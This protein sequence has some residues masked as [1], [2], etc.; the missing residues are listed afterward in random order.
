MG[1]SGGPVLVTGASSG[2]G[3]STVELLGSMGHSVLAGARRPEDLESLS[4]I[5]NLSP[6]SLDVTRTEDVEMAVATVRSQGRGL[7][8][9]VNTA[10]IGNLGPLAEMTVEEIHDVLAVNFDGMCRM[11]TAMFPLLQESKGRVIN[12]SSIGGFLVE[13]LLGPYNISKHAVEAYSDVL[14]EEVAPFGVRVIT[15]EPGAFQTRIYDKSLIRFA[16]AIRQKWAHSSSVFRD[17]VLQTLAYLEQ[18]EVRYRKNYPLPV[19]VARVI[20][21]ALF[22]D[23]PK[24]RYLVG[25]VKEANAVV[26][27]LLE[28]LRQVNSS[29]PG[30]L[31]RDELAERLDR[32]GPGR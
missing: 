16:E 21:E 10:G 3:R 23:N 15:I 24:P 13:P 17:Q 4:R 5:E 12:I 29:H 26:D 22:T 19:P 1:A 14:R 25:T 30:K 28:V 2:I 11:V 18:P 27:R 8:G 20:A 6:I 7:Y 32:Q 31:S 9:L